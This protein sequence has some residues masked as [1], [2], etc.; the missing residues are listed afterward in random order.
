MTFEGCKL[1]TVKFVADRL[2]ADKENQPGR[3][4]S[5]EMIRNWERL[6]VEP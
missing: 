1:N 2:L 3:T 4:P 5:S 6:A